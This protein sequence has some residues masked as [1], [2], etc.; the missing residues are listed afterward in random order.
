MSP[1]RGQLQPLR[2]LWGLVAHEAVIERA[3]FFV[4]AYLGHQDWW[5]ICAY[6]HTHILTY[7]R[8]AIQPS[9][10]S[11]SIRTGRFAGSCCCCC[12]TSTLSSLPSGSSPSWRQPEPT[13]DRAPRPRRR[14]DATTR[15]PSQT[16]WSSCL[17]TPTHTYMYIYIYRYIYGYID[18]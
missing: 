3:P 12:G 18:M 17:P 10:H 5:V 16:R 13:R 1:A 6:T 2:R 15:G 9:I 7:I 8:T 4:A 11:P 14:R